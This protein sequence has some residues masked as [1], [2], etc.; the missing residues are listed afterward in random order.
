MPAVAAPLPDNERAR[1]EALSTYAV[2]D[3]APEAAFDDLTRIAS[4]ICGTPMS[5]VSLIDAD[6]Q[7]FKSEVGL[8]IRETPRDQA[9]CAH[10]ILQDGVFVVPDAA[11]DARFADNPLVTGAVNIRFYAGAPLVTPDGY[12]LGTLCVIDR[13]PRTL[14]AEQTDTLR[15]L[16]RQVVA[17]LE[18]RRHLG[19]LHKAYTR[20]HTVDRLK[21]EFVSMVSHELRTPLTSIRGGLQL[22][23]AD[24]DA[25][26]DADSRELLGRA[27]HSS[28]RLIRLT[29]DILDLSKVEAG[30]MEIK[31]SL[32]RAAELVGNACAAVAHLPYGADRVRVRVDDGIGD[33]LVDPDRIVQALVNLLANGLKF[34]PPPG[35]VHVEVRQ[36]GGAVV[37]AVRDEGPG[38]APEDLVRLFQPFQQLAGARKVG[39]TGLGLVISRAIIEQH[40]GTLTVTSRLGVGT[41]FTI[42]LSSVSASPAALA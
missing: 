35:L 8:G 41:T 33:L 17:Q 12:P 7:W 26:P 9:F 3:T 19:E 14:N 24:A 32:S 34:T 16:S 5:V 20:L 39:G 21:S 31:P 36:Q 27:L 1:L 2:L 6:R 18:M 37:M 42:T 22:V 11:A 29:N 15:A 28:E 13:V 4:Y 38:I 30:R 40:G 23:L 10:A 25:V